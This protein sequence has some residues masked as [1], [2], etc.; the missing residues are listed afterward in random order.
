MATRILV[1]EDNAASRELACYLLQSAGLD[2]PEASDG[3]S[4]LA[5][6]RELVPDLVICDLQLPGMDG[7]AVL[8]ALRSDP[9][10]AGIPVVAV[11][12]FSMVGDRDRVLAAGFNGYLAKPVDPR[13]FTA[14]ITAFLE[15]G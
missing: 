12:A 6:A 14:Q 8:Q 13:K 10:T 7:F 15:Q 1:I 9:A 11:T 2:A 5:M 4:G 3:E